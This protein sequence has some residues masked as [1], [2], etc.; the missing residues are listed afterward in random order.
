M[1]SLT[2]NSQALVLIFKSGTYGDFKK[3]THANTYMFAH[4]NTFI[5]GDFKKHAKVLILPKY[6]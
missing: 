3:H 4:A 2:R 1:G 5:Y 6:V